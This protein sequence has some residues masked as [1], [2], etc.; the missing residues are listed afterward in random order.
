[1]LYNVTL[2]KTENKVLEMY[3][4]MRAEKKGGKYPIPYSEA[5]KEKE[6]D[7]EPSKQEIAQFLCDS[8]MDFV[9]VEQNYRFQPDLP[10][11]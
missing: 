1:M 5:I 2:Q 6:L 3:Y 7:H 8:K 4:V 9:Y 11:N 10:F